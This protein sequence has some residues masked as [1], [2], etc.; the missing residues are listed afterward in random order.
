[1]K[2]NNP[3]T[4]ML[5]IIQEHGSKYNPPSIQLAEV[6]AP[7]PDLIIK[8]GDIQVDKKNILIADYLLS[9]YNRAYY[10]NGRL[11]FKDENLGGASDQNSCQHPHSHNMKSI[12]TDT[13]DYCIEGKGKDGSGDDRNKFLWF[14]DTLFKGDLLAVM[15]TY[16]MQMYIV[17]ARV[18]KSDAYPK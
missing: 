18:V 3:Y 5:G 11:I 4:E 15:P 16:D 14:N 8:L 9:G 7:P 13:Y 12:E 10:A 1:M 17:L 2:T 6:L